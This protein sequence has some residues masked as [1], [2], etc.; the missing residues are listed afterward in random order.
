MATAKIIRDASIRVKVQPATKERLDRI[1]HLFGV[2]PSTL[3]SVWIGQM[4]TQQERSLSMLSKM[5][6]SVGGEMGKAMAQQLSMMPELFG[7]EAVAGTAAQPAVE[8]QP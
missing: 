1:A 3:A 5:A 7:G 8:A 6:D 4:L 2:P